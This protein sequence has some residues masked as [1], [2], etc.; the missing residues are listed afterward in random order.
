[1]SEYSGGHAATGRRF[2][3]VVSRYN[4]VVTEPLV[5]G[6]RRTLV[7]HGA[8]EADVD[9][10]RVPGAWELPAAVREAG[11]K[12]F[13]CDTVR[14]RPISPPPPPPPPPRLSVTEKT[15]ITFGVITAD[16]MEQARDR[17][18]GKHGHKGEEAAMA[19]LE[20]CDVLEQLS[21]AGR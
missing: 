13:V 8:R 6:A 18:G 19:A 1:M 3:L 2:C 7:R 5:D 15:P 10:V 4:R 21:R 9:V 20:L 16:T 11:G 14:I 12:P 17:A